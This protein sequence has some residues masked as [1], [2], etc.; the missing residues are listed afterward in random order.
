MKPKQR[1]AELHRQAFR[2]KHPHVPEYGIPK[3]SKTDNS[4]NALTRMIIDW[5]EYNGGH[6]ERVNSMGRMVDN[7]KEVT[8]VVGRRYMIGSKKYLPSTGKKG[9]TD[10]HAVIRGRAVMIEVKFG[11]DRQSAVQ[12]EYEQT[13]TQAGAVYVIARTFDQFVEWWDAYLESF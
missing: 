13:V 11:K 2:L 3:Y 5:I 7:R 6:A 9:T 10:I 8:D 1:I 12:K 4:A